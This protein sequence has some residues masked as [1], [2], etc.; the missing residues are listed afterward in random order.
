[1]F[2]YDHKGIDEYIE[3]VNE[4]VD[5]LKNPEKY[6]NLGARLPKGILLV[7]EPGVGRL[8]R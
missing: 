6:E 8:I 2:W 4:L 1:M 7:G 5:I 3:E